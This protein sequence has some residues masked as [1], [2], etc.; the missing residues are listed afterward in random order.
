MDSK[1]LK[2]LNVKEA[3][4]EPPSSHSPADLPLRREKDS[5]D[6]FE[7]LGLDS[8]PLQEAIKEGATE[9][10]TAAR[11]LLGEIDKGLESAEKAASSIVNDVFDPF[12]K[13]PGLFDNPPKPNREMDSNLLHMGD[14]IVVD[15]KETEDK[16]DKFLSELTAAPPVPSHEISPSQEEM[17]AKLDGVKAATQNFMDTEREK[18]SFVPSKISS[19]DDFLDRY[20]YNEPEP[21]DNKKRFNIPV[22]QD[23]PDPFASSHPVKDFQD[24]F[25]DDFDPFKEYKDV[26]EPELPTKSVF[27]KQPSPVKEIMKPSAPQEPLIPAPKITPSVPLIPEPIKEKISEP[28]IEEKFVEFKKED[29]IIEPKKEE[30][31]IEVKKEEK[32]VEP[33]K[34][35]KFVEL[36]KE[37]FVEP[38]KE[39]KADVKP[40]P[41]PVIETKPKPAITDAEA[42]FKQMGL[43]AWF[44]P[45]RLN[46]RVESLIYWRDPKKSGP[47]FGGVLVVL[48]ALTYFSLISVVAYLSLLALTATISFRI[49]KN[50]VQAV[51]KT[52]DGHPF[53]EFLETDVA[54]PQDKVKEVVEIAVAH[55]NAAIAELRR[56]FLV[57]DLVDSI[58]FGVL[59]WC[60][61]YLG[62][63]FNGMTL[64]IIAWVALFTL[65][66]VYEAN[67][68][69]IDA[70]L[71]LVRSKLAE[72]TSKN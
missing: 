51:Q 18:I 3:G 10:S 35:E 20:S 48:L 60:L 29:I 69:Q 24:A 19:N 27:E 45:E 37:K 68:T 22:K 44:H 2:D 46:P 7:H 14:T 50:V 38:K 40:T 42:I 55:I 70:N 32:I 30:K 15:K 34:E 43:D 56:L 9:V 4:V 57:E 58:K 63:W 53:K 66:K 23:I 41:K 67:K 64:V 61:T 8:S 71:D 52:G 47:V 31:I 33:K 54:L 62:A 17:K 16:L 11:D 13:E 72:I 25:K 49:Y 21:E 5:L 1:D 36:K 39:I 59:L 28:K 6:D 65:P 26:K 12:K